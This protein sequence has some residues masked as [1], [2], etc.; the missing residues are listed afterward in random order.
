MTDHTDTSNDNVGNTIQADASPVTVNLANTPF[1]TL[2]Q[3]TVLDAVESLGYVSDL[4][5]FPLNSYENRVYQVG[6]EGEAPLIAKFYRPNRWNLQQIREEHTFSLALAELEIPVVPPIANAEGETLFEY[7]DHRFS[8][9]QRRGGH[10]PSLDDMDTLYRMGQHL[11]RIHALGQVEDYN[12]RPALTLEDF[13]IRSREY[14]LANDFIPKTLLAAYQT[15][16]EQLIDKMQSVITNIDYRSIRLHGDCHPGNVLQRED[17][18]YFVDFDDSRMGP[19]IQDIW[20]LL[21]GDKTQQQTQ[22]GEILEG[23]EEFCEFNP[24]ELPLIE[25]FRTLRLMHYA[26]WLARRWEDPAFPQAFPWF[27]SE[28]YWAEHIQ[29]LREQLFGLD[30]PA[31]KLPSAI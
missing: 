25:S 28:R 23:Y 19:A 30:E 14:L 13:G 5:V 8:L 21:S 31:L 7:G 22:F 15:V 16:S 26:A 4:R 2:T 29:E 11:G 12:H 9:S 3:D 1:H 6:I 10:A 24:S 20:M 18:L 17:S 27:N